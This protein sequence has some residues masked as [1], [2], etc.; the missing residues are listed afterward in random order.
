MPGGRERDHVRIEGGDGDPTGEDGGVVELGGDDLLRLRMASLLLAGRATRTP[1]EVVGWFGAMQAQDLASGEW[2]FGV[3]CEGLTQADVHQAT[4]DR[5]ILRTWPMRGTVHFVPPRDARWMLEVTGV[6]ALAGAER[7]RAHLGLSEA[8][9]DRA[10]AVLGEALHGGGC[11]TRSE[12][13]DLLVDAGIHTA[14][15]H[16]YHLLWYASQIGVTCIGPQRGKEQTFV[17]LDEWVPDPHRMSRDDA[18]AE[19]AI[20][21]FRGHGP[22][23][24]Q[25]LAGW[26]GLPAADVRR[27]IDLAGDALAAVE[28]DGRPMVLS[29]ALLDTAPAVTSGGAGDDLLLLPGFDELVLGY[30]DRSAVLAPE[31][32][33]RVLPGRNGVFM[34]TIVVGGRVVGTWKRTVKGR[35]VEVVPSPFRPLS[36]DQE[37]AFLRARDGY[38]AYLQLE[39]VGP[40]NDPGTDGD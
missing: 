11:L 13:I 1:A 39:G 19:L 9:V 28:V 34:P 10:A 16:G 23:T 40:S 6:R 31:H 5:T 25:D 2:S 24:R 33:Q 29:S 12:C 21:Y 18:L 27:G 30:K 22:A 7:R 36:G 35:R 32:V 38:A 20:R 14:P 4:V 26:T 3:R 8:T 37:G 15:E 17:L